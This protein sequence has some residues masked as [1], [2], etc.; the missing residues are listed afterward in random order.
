MSQVPRNTRIM[1]VVA[2]VLMLL[3]SG[4]STAQDPL[5]FPPAPGEQPSASPLDGA[6]TVA[7][8][9]PNYKVE[10]ADKA[11]KMRDGR[12]QVLVELTT[13]AAVTVSGV[14]GQAGVARAN[15]QRAAIRAEQVNFA[16]AARGIGASPIAAT[17]FLV[18][19]VTVA[20][21]PDALPALAALPNVKGVYPNI[22]IERNDT[23][24][25]PFINADDAWTPANGG[26]TGAGKIIAIIDSGIDYTHR[27]FG[28]A[29]NYNVAAKNRRSLAD[30]PMPGKGALLP[31]TDGAPKVIGGHDYV[32][33]AYDGGLV[34][35]PDPDP[36][37]C[38]I[39]EG[40]G[41]GTHV[42]GTAAGWGVEANGSTYAGPFDNTI[43]TGYPANT[44]TLR[45][46]P[47]VAPRAALVALKVFGCD[48]STTSSDVI[49][50]MAD[51]VAGTYAD[52][53]QADVINMSLGSAYGLASANNPYNS[54]VNAA[55]DAGTLVVMSAGNSGNWFFIN[56]SPGVSNNGISVAWSLDVGNMAR[57]VEDDA[58][59]TVYAAAYGA[60]SP[61]IHPALTAVSV[62]ANPANGCGPLQNAAVVKG[63]IVLIDRGVCGFAD[64]QDNAFKAGAAGV[65]IMNNVDDSLLTMVAPTVA[66]YNLPTVF[67]GLSS[68]AALKA[69]SNGT[70]TVT[71][72]W[73]LGIFL[74]ENGDTVSDSSSRGPGRGNAGAVKPD[75]SAPG[76][77]I[78][79]AG[80]GTNQW[81][82]NISGTSMAAPH[83]AGLMALLM[84]ANPTWDAYELKALAISTA[85]SD[86]TYT[87]S[88]TTFA[89]GPQRVGT[90]RIDALNAVT[91]DAI[92]YSKDNK[93]GVSVSF[94]FP[95]TVYG[96]P[97][98]NTITATVAS[99]SAA[100]IE[101]NL[102]YLARTLA[103]GASYS[104][105]PTTLNV[106]A[107]GT[108]DFT[109]TLNYNPTT[110]PN[111]N[112]DGSLSITASR[113]RL[114]E[115]AGVVELTPTTPGNTLRLAVYA[116]PRA[117]SAMSGAVADSTFGALIGTRQINLT[118]TGMD[119]GPSSS[120]LL[121]IVTPFELVHTSPNEANTADHADLQY[122]G[123]AS[124]YEVAT[125]TNGQT[126]W[127]IATHDDWNTLNEVEFGVYLDFDQNGVP[128]FI[129]VNGY[130]GTGL[131]QFSVSV[132]D[133][134]NRLG[135]GAGAL[136]NLGNVPNGV[137][138]T[139]NTYVMRNRVVMLPMFTEYINSL[140]LTDESP[141]F[142]YF[143]ETYG[144][145]GLVDTVGSPSSPLTYNP[146]R[147]TYS[148][149]GV[150]SG[151]QQFGLAW[152]D[153]AGENIPV[154]FDLRL[155]NEAPDI[156]LLH[157]HNAAGTE[158]QVIDMS[159][160]SALVDARFDLLS[161]A[162][163][164]VLR[165][166]AD[167]A[168]VTE[169]TWEQPSVGDTFTFELI[170]PDGSDVT[171]PNLTAAADADNLT[172]AAGVCTLSLPDTLLDVVNGKGRYTWN[173]YSV[174]AEGINPATN[175]FSFRVVAGPQEFT[176]VS[177]S[178]GQLLLSPFDLLTVAW[179]PSDNN[180]DV[181]YEFTLSK[182]SNNRV[183]LG[184]VA[185]LT[186]LTSAA[187]AD[188]LTCDFVS[189]TPL[190][191]LQF[192]APLDLDNGT[193]NWSVVASVAG[194]STEASN[195][196]FTFKMYVNDVE[197]VRNGS[198]EV[199][200]ANANVAAGWAMTNSTNDQRVVNPAAAK[201]GDAFY[202]F[203][204][205]ANE[206]SHLTQ[207]LHQ[208]QMFKDL[209]G[210]GPNAELLFKA[211]ARTGYASP[212]LIVRLFVDYRWNGFTDKAVVLRFNAPTNGSYEL[213]AESV[214][215][216]GKV[217][218]LTLKVINR[219][220]GGQVNVDDISVLLPGFAGP[221]ETTESGT[222]PTVEAPANNGV[223][224]M[225]EQPSDNN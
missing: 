62:V 47:G 73:R 59:N 37:D 27:H 150:G 34:P 121:S 77:T 31:L 96:T 70:N 145:G 212:N 54:A 205:S 2:L 146:L 124:N 139:L 142:N 126:F 17:D 23:T 159:V 57:G 5:P 170:R 16:N 107:G 123:I 160:D 108:A 72:D 221:D 65:I 68:G 76:N 102:A 75:L 213:K 209:D 1:A 112:G 28:G 151:T 22:E 147:P 202:R 216:E 222:T 79:S 208:T 138:A 136:R 185:K 183:P 36:L 63:K 26:F 192:A 106:P 173:V 186:A 25:V 129:V 80:S 105:N 140:V 199:A 110:I 135:F 127:A 197:F 214:V 11:V 176:L 157:H 21:S 143:I 91:S 167:L 152:A 49:A 224:P 178:N 118:G 168:A 125:P 15:D 30:L 116:A 218:G 41:H 38:R 60:G 201:T 46:G 58:T 128:E 78:L 175:E 134:D 51:A 8:A 196:P 194:L 154:D 19:V 53:R 131:D 98:S 89:H 180:P 74:A 207:Q 7:A 9:E 193:Y 56:G 14:G 81:T 95:E 141:E 200:G 20:V 10:V 6:S 44:A 203:K 210:L 120:D 67:V 133:L 164:A 153:L 155:V 148:F 64:K 130:S 33:D 223:I 217:K 172:C 92:V 104:V 48:G 132:Y 55:M 119:T 190:C 206:N 156:L 195:S 90:G 174:A 198:F 94:G 219:S 42:A 191:V 113:H 117:V 204:G 88:A 35:N 43:F 97:Y 103:S 189:A 166:I 85:T 171:I 45:I 215:L 187:D 32:G 93:E 99:T 71:M 163:G 162:N 84:E 12:I 182:I 158:A 220:K 169:I 83:V 115:A 109:I 101:Y 111:A 184:E 137:N 3:V 4:I 39:T 100:D 181:V 50:A 114:T 211:S 188:G 66:G 179:T 61:F 18:N 24:S 82:Y 52:G 165:T 161:P 13:P 122:V 86:V 177:P 40:G 225:P 69:S 29:G 144:D 87:V 149:Q